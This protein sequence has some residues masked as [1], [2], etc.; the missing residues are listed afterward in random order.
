M[1][2]NAAKHP[3]CLPTITNLLRYRSHLTTLTRAVQ[4]A[5]PRCSRPQCPTDS[6]NLTQDRSPTC[7]ACT[8]SLTTIQ[9]CTT[10]PPPS[11]R[12]RS[13]GHPRCIQSPC[14][15]SPTLS[16]LTAS[17]C[18]TPKPSR[19][20]QPGF[21]RV[22]RRRMDPRSSLSFIR[23]GMHLQGVSPR[24]TTLFRPEPCPL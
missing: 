1:T 20:T 4:L 7:R 14:A 15:Q 11:P 18:R 5:I 6:Y 2:S 21:T 10:R 24:K 17:P 19:H 12:L 3:R 9:S 22:P 23:T 8:L 16:I 13:L